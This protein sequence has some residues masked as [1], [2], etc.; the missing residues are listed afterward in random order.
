MGIERGKFYWSVGRLYGEVGS[1]FKEYLLRGVGGSRTISG[2]FLSIKASQV[3]KIELA[4]N[5]RYRLLKLYHHR[6]PA[7]YNTCLHITM[8]TKSSALVASGL[9]LV[10]SGA[11]IGTSL[12]LSSMAV[13][14]LLVPHPTTTKEASQATLAGAA[15]S[16]QYMYDVGKKAGPVTGLIGSAAY[17]Y[18]AYALPAALKTERRLLLAAAVAN[19]LVGPFTV[20]F[21]ARTNDELIRRANGAKAGQQAS[22][23][24]KDAKQGSIESYD[25]PSL[26]DRWSKLNASRSI[27]PL[28]AALLAAAA[29]GSWF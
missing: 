23:E 26:L 28:A 17:A 20:I 18:A 5:S 16:W 2:L 22:H 12:T 15:R 7:G 19:S 3:L 10:M 29:L 27:Y 24:N 1:E 11:F 6:Q 4:T 25:T 9:G 8:A 13:P 14:S 21:M